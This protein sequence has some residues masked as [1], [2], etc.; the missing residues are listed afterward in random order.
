MSRYISDQKTGTLDFMKYLY[1]AQDILS[2]PLSVPLS[3]LSS[4]NLLVP[5]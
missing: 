4:Q 5:A 2:P 3:I 1:K